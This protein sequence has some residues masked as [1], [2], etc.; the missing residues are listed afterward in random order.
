MNQYKHSAKRAFIAWLL[1][2]I[3]ILPMVVRAVHVCQEEC[4]PVG[5]SQVT[6]SEHHSQGHNPEKCPICHFAF[7]SFVKPDA[8]QTG[9]LF[10]ISL[11]IT[12]LFAAAAIF[13]KQADAISLRAPPT[14]A[15]A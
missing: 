11:G 10:A 9:T 4:S 1:L 5:P 2:A 13:R 6:Y 14:L 12:I 7:F 15:I 8:V 3:F